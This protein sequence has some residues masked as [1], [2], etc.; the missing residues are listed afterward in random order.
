MGGLEFKS[1]P[2]HEAYWVISGK[3]PS[4]SLTNLPPRIGVRIKGETG[5][6]EA[7]LRAYINVILMK[8]A[9]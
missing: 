7:A 1:P 3:S 2:D 9:A 8:I 5:T 4:L 6:T